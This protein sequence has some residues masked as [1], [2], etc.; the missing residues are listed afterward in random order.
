MTTPSTVP[1]LVVTD[2]RNIVPSRLSTETST[3]SILG[4]VVP[5][6]VEVWKPGSLGLASC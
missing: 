3:V 1:I 4:F 2:G 6:K 5:R